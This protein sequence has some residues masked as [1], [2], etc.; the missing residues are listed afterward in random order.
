MV[1]LRFDTGPQGVET[2]T[3]G[4]LLLAAVREAGGLHPMGKRR[5]SKWV[6]HDLIDLQQY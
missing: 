2:Q 5:F 4:T 3:P 1:A 6:N